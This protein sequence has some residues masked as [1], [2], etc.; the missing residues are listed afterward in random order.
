MLTRTLSF[1]LSWFANPS[2]IGVGLAV[3]FGAFWLLVYRPPLFR[4]PWLWAVMVVSAFLSL[5]G[6]AFVQIPLQVIIG[7]AIGQAAMKQMPLLAGIPGIL[8]SGFIQE[9]TKLLPIVGYWWRRDRQIDPLLGLALGA[10]AGA[11]FGV[12]EAQWVH[13]TVFASGWEWSLVRTQGTVALAAFAERFSTVAFHI[14]AS[15]LAGYG[16]ARGWGWQFYLLAAFLHAVAN[17]GAV[18][19][20][21][22]TW[23]L[24]E[25]E[26]FVAVVA[27]V[28]TF[29]ALVLRWETKSNAD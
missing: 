14:A 1:F 8:L 11:G 16:L 28:T 4:N 15:A 17:Y 20:Q 23:A 24:A 18:L 27:G 25:V 7:Q 9:A 29:F 6:V 13:N 21:T 3:A 26:I 12:L 2:L 19:Y 10:V 22:Q 5:A